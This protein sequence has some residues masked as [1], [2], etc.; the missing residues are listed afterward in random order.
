MQMDK[1]IKNGKLTT[2]L[3][4]LFDAE[5]KT[6]TIM[7]LAIFLNL[8]KPTDMGV[9]LQAGEEVE[10]ISGTLSEIPVVALNYPTFTDGRAYSSANILRRKYHYKGE[11]RAI[12]DVRIDQLEQMSRCGFDA[13]QLDEN[14]DIEKALNVLLKALSYSYQPTANQ[15]PLFSKREFYIFYNFNITYL[16]FD[17]SS[18][19]D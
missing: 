11:I 19:I 4:Q 13:Y 1:V 6:G 10:R 18:V 12:G 2:P 5:K 14:Q 9:W 15:P 3:Y 16:F 17:I 8:R 7:P